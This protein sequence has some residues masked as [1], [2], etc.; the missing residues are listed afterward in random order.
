[1]IQSTFSLKEDNLFKFLQLTRN[2]LDSKSVVD[3]IYK[4]EDVYINDSD[5]LSY[6]EDLN[7]VFVEN[8]TSY[9]MKIYDLYGDVVDITNYKSKQENLKETKFNITSCLHVVFVYSF[10]IVYPKKSPKGLKVLSLII[11]G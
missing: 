10:L 6:V 8:K 2:T 9:Y 11:F 3:Q 7:K 4:M 1:M 5:T